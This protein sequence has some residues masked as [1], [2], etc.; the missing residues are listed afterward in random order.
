MN[1]KD[2]GDWARFL[3]LS[4]GKRTLLT[5]TRHTYAYFATSG[6]FPTPPRLIGLLTTGL[7]DNL[8]RGRKN[9]AYFI[10]LPWP[11]INIEYPLGLN[12]SL[13]YLISCLAGFLLLAPGA[14]LKGM[15]KGEWLTIAPALSLEFPLPL[16]LSQSHSTFFPT[17]LTWLLE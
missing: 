14:L 4:R 11:F 1:M 13:A 5:S 8:P 12:E 15:G 7:K 9:L 16:L 17:W 6:T 10:E 2:P 3:Y